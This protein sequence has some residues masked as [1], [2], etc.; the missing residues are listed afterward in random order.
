MLGLVFSNI[1]YAQTS[2]H[3]TIVSEKNDKPIAYATVSVPQ[4]N[5]AILADGSGNF[6][7][8]YRIINVSDTFN[9]SSVGYST[10]RLAVRD[11]QKISVIR[12]K[13]HTSD[14]ENV[15]LFTNEA[16]EGNKLE[17]SGY[18]R[19]WPTKSKG[20]EIGKI[21]VTKANE[22]LVDRIRFK[23]NN[24]C[25]ACQVR[26]RIR[27]VVNGFPGEE[28]FT[29]SI[30]MPV[31]KLNFDDHYSE[32]DLSKKQIVLKQKSVFV[33]LEVL[34][35]TGEP[36]SFC[37][38]GTEPGTFMYKNKANTIWEESTSHNLYLRFYY[39]Y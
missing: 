10:Y 22:F 20:G 2:Y 37:F 14:L 25:N 8:S 6:N 11:A 9:I 29:D 19:S 1:S 36:C 38:I 3:A 16:V 13:E 30:S 15:T 23:V 34:Y 5:I 39:K 26:L 31:K 33:S 24:Q 17:K 18:F 4:K 28:L 27:E 35:C 32:F 21:F 7:V 12:L